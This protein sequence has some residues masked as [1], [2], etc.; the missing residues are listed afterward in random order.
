MSRSIIETSLPES[1]LVQPSDLYTFLHGYPG[2]EDDFLTT[3]I[4]AARNEVEGK[5]G[6]CLAPRTF[7][8]YADHFPMFAYMTSVWGPLTGVVMPW[9]GG[10]ISALPAGFEPKRNPFEMQLWRSPVRSVDR[11]TYCD[12]TT[13]DPVTL[14]ADTDYIADVSAMPARIWPAPGKI[15]PTAQRRPQSVAIDFTAGYSTD[16]TDV[17]DGRVMAYPPILKLIVMQLAAYWYLHRDMVGTTPDAI[18]DLILSNRLA[19][20][21]PDIR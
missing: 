7:T 16:P 11:I 15:W 3:L 12:P 10:P 20:Y 21:N 5:S 8:Q 14:A 6:Y 17:V 9:V 19:D 2:T 1:E 4:A 18:N 13:G